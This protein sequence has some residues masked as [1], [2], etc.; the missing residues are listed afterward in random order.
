MSNARSATHAGSGA[1]QPRFFGFAAFLLAVD[2][3]GRGAGLRRT[4]RAALLDDFAP[5]RR[6]VVLS[7]VL[8]GLRPGTLAGRRVPR[9]RVR[10]A[11]PAARVF[12]PALRDFLLGLRVFS[13]ALRDFLLGLRD[14][15]LGLRVFS[16]GVRV[17]LPEAGVGIPSAGRVEVNARIVF[18]TVG[19]NGI[20]VGGARGRL[21]P[22]AITVV[23]GGGGGA[24]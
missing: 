17:A 21:I 13:P 20:R 5:A 11:L 14:F 24:A 18:E 6:F 22:G 19:T 10:A 9:G 2:L 7:L 12:S 15:L 1:L 3:R 4:C 23:A 16:V 8:A